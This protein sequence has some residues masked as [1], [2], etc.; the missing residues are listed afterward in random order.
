MEDSRRKPKATKVG[1]D[2]IWD[3][4]SHWKVRIGELK[5]QQG[6]QGDERLFKAVAEKIP[7]GAINKV[8][9]A[10]KKM[11]V[12]RTGVY[13]AHDSM[14][15]ARYIGIIPRLKA[16][17]RAQPLELCY[18]SFYVVDKKT[19]ELEIETLLIRAAGPQ[20]HF[21]SKKKR[22]DIAP[23]NVGDY[24]AGTRYFQRQHKSEK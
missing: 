2:E 23:G 12:P 22:V 13:I 1:G 19:H 4:G 8:A 21:N 20:L 10:L 5:R 9:S 24:E 16:R 17:K 18:F 6:R 11:G 15:V 14:G 7:F 3:D